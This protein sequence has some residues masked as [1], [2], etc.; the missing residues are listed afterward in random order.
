M[1]LK[2]FWEFF[3]GLLGL[4]HLTFYLCKELLT[5]PSSILIISVL[6]GDTLIIIIQRKKKTQNNRQQQRKAELEMQWKL[7]SSEIYLPL[8]QGKGDDKNDYTC[9]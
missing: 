6:V 5:S 9:V 3:S 1:S 2:A 4:W 7:N 8:H